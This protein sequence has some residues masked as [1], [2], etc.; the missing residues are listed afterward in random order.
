[1]VEKAAHGRKNLGSGVSEALDVSPSLTI[2]SRLR[3]AFLYRFERDF[4]LVSFVFSSLP[5]SCF[6][7][8]YCIISAFRKEEAKR[9]RDKQT[10]NETKTSKKKQKRMSTAPVS[11]GHSLAS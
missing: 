11:L 6:P 5:F 2:C 10:R 8:K 9:Q 1:M 3:E 7:S 4:L